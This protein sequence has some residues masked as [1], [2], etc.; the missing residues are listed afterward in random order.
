MPFRVVSSRFLLLCLHL[1]AIGNWSFRSDFL[2]RRNCACHLAQKCNN[3]TQ[4]TVKAMIALQALMSHAWRFDATDVASAAAAP[5]TMTP[6]P[7]PSSSAPPASAPAAR[8]GSTRAGSPRCRATAP[9][10]P[11]SR[12]ASCRTAA[13]RA[14]AWGTSA[15]AGLGTAYQRQRRWQ[16]D[17]SC[18][19][20]FGNTLGAEAT[21]C[22]RRLMTVSQLSYSTSVASLGLCCRVLHYAFNEKVPFR[23]QCRLVQI[24]TT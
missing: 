17:C 20:Q 24:C 9:P 14:P 6:P 22:N 1:G 21:Y 13:A 7:S 8:A 12:P 11:P 19:G 3:V 23:R 5:A 18:N 10:P 15:T 4:E 16:A 2:I